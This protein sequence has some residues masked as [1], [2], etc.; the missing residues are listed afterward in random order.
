MMN[1]LGSVP[2][3]FDDGP[4]AIQFDDPAS[5]DGPKESGGAQVIQRANA[6]AAK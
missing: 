6:T 2:C 1:L 3:P 5:F 4:V